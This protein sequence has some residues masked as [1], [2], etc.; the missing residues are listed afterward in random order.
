MY[1]VEVDEY[2]SSQICALCHTRTTKLVQNA[3]AD[4]IYPVLVCSLCNTHWN[5]YHMA[6]LN[7][8]SVF[9]YIANH[10]NGYPKPF[11]RPPKV[12]DTTHQVLTMLKNIELLKRFK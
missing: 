6:S 10:K 7:M 4:D 2:L 5:W 9:M 11:V 3:I 12:M 8:R 1:L